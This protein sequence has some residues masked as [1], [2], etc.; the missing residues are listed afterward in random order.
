MINIKKELDKEDMVLLVLPSKGYSDI[1]TKIV[2]QL[3]DEM[4]GGLYVTLNNPYT[5]L[6]KRFRTSGIN[7]DACFFI[8]AISAEALGAGKEAD[9]CVFVSS[10]NALTELGIAI[11]TYIKEQKPKVLIF[12]SLST[13]PIYVPNETILKFA[14][15]MTTRIREA[16]VKAVF[17]IIGNQELVRS[18]GM[19]I[20]RTLEWEEE[21]AKKA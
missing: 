2:K 5:V 7:C 13:L 18:M 6:M 12:D 9:N 3:D 8:D 20:S 11:N 16:G 15:N 21:G 10:P 19:F 14:Q 1:L 17:P 4:G